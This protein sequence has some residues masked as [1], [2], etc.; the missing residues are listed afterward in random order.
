ME[1]EVVELRNI[2]LWLL[3]HILVPIPGAHQMQK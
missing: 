2:K 3:S 1:T